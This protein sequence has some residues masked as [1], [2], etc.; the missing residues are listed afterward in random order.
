M[1]KSI[2]HSVWIWHDVE[3]YKKAADT[4]TQE[5]RKKVRKKDREIQRKRER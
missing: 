1:Y 5:S 2:K 3:Y 4:V